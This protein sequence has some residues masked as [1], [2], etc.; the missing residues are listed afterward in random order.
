MAGSAGGAC[1]AGPQWALLS[2]FVAVA[3]AGPG[4][5]DAARKAHVPSAGAALTRRRK[6]ARQAH[7]L[8]PSRAGDTLPERL[9]TRADAERSYLQKRSSFAQWW[10]PHRQAWRTYEEPGLVLSSYVSGHCWLGT[11]C[12]ITSQTRAAAAH[13]TLSL[14]K[15]A[16]WALPQASK[17]SAPWWRRTAGKSWLPLPR[18]ATSAI[19]N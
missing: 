15:R 7:G 5:A 9:A 8:R 19:A 13:V 6:L 16:V 14:L 11:A 10:H 18:L 4:G 3:T 2:A 1:C 17:T 12:N